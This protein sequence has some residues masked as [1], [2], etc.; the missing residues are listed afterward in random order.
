MSFQALLNSTCDIEEKTE[1]Q[2]AQT[3]EMVAT[4]ASLHTDVECRIVDKN[5]INSKTNSSLY[6]KSTHMLYMEYK[7]IDCLT[8]R[9]LID[10]IPYKIYGVSDM[11]S[12]EKY[13]C[14]YLAKY[15]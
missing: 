6:Q 12:S 8:H 11:G 5:F 13:L 2:N 3:G 14:L 7:T 15:E 1:T 9:V 4:W 10:D